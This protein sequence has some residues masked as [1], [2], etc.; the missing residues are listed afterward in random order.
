MEGARTDVATGVEV[1]NG[2]VTMEVV[3]AGGWGIKP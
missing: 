1:G 2:A 3:V